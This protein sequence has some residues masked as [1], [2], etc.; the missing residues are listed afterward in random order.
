MAL[1]HIIIFLYVLDFNK[2]N[3]PATNTLQ[4]FNE[5]NKK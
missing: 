1:N 3:N 5:K 4:Y 2:K